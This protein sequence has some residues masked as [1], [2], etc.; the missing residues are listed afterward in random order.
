MSYLP[1]DFV[2]TAEGLVFAVVD[3]FGDEARIPCF[4]RYRPLPDGRLQKLA[5]DAANTLLRQFHPKYL[6]QCERR[7]AALHGVRPGDVVRHLTPRERVRQLLGEGAANDPFEARAARLVHVLAAH[8]VAIDSVGV[9]GSVLIA[10][11]GTHSDID[12]VIYDE[13]AFQRARDAVPLLIRDG[14]F[15]ALDEEAWADAYRRRG[16]ALN[17]ETFHW[18]EVRKHNKA[19]FEGTKFDLSLLTDKPT[20][21]SSPQIWRKLGATRIQATVT[22]D[23]H[24]FHYPARLGIDNPDVGEVLAF[25]ATY[26]GQARTG[27]RIEV[28]GKL[29]QAADG[30][31]RIIVGSDRESVGQSIRVLGSSQ[32]DSNRQGQ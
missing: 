4:L 30:R 19:V 17:Q 22:D 29:E 9:T 14:V 27:E 26:T 25:T 23:R 6:Y 15:T 20:S 3:R 28:Q 18:H 5:T 11:H 24:A 13:T 7:Q 32:A 8:G 2:V 21:A 10:S 1:R 12:L 31:Q 16:C